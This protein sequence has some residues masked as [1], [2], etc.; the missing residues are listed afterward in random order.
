MYYLDSLMI[1]YK[2]GN[3][4]GIFEYKKDQELKNNLLER[5]DQFP[6]LPFMESQIK[7][8]M[9]EYVEG[10]K[11]NSLTADKCLAK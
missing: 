7:A 1:E 3:L 8:I 5:R 11:K 10:M 9:Q 4:T 2:S 6:Q